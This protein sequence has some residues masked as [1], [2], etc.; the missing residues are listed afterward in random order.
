VVGEE[1]V[2]EP[3]AMASGSAAGSVGAALVTESGGPEYENV[4]AEEDAVVA[5][6]GDEEE[7]G[8]IFS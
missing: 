1:E 5:E 6:E 3:S 2:L 4:N 8:G 7:R